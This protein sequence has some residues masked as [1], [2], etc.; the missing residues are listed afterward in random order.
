MKREDN[1][2][3]ITDPKGLNRQWRR[4]LSKS[5]GSL[6]LCVHA[7]ERIL[8]RFPELQKLTMNEF[9]ELIRKSEPQNLTITSDDSSFEVASGK[10]VF[11]VGSRD[12]TLVTLF[13]NRKE[14]TPEVNTGR[15]PKIKKPYDRSKFKQEAKREIKES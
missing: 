2:K 10:I 11:V 3:R 9:L 7:M 6:N 12:D 4:F 8:E 5:N 14:K 1:E 15:T 13:R